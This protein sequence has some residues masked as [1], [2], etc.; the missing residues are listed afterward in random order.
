MIGSTPL[1]FNI[2]PEK[3]PFEKV[4]FQGMSVL[5]RVWFYIAALWYC[6]SDLEHPG[7]CMLLRKMR[8]RTPEASKSRSRYR[9]CT[10]PSLFDVSLIYKVLGFSPPQFLWLINQA[11]PTL[12][13]TKQLWRRTPFTVGFWHVYTGL[14]YGSSNYVDII[15]N[16]Y[17][18]PY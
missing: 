10:T 4:S 1:K 5:G 15:I 13:T 8:F 6:G 14:Y 3:N 16:H 11:V 7:W 9:V 12:L 17:K 2:A 18:N